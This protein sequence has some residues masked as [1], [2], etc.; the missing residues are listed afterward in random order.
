MDDR[1]ALIPEFRIAVSIVASEFLLECYVAGRGIS[2]SEI[3][4][5]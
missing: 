3:R 1:A 4:A 5:T 2:V